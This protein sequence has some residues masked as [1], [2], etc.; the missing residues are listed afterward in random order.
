MDAQLVHP[1][2]HASTHLIPGLKAWLASSIDHLAHLGLDDVKKTEFG[3]SAFQ[4]SLRFVMIE[5][6]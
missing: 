6:C 2:A 1:A 3:W 5:L 4:V